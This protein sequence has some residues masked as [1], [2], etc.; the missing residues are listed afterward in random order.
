MGKARPLSRK[1]WLFLMKKSVLM[2][3]SKGFVPFDVL[4]IYDD[5]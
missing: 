1:A 3:G 5:T 4:I 2:R